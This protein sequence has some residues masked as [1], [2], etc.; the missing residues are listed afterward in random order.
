MQSENDNWSAAANVAQVAA[1]AVSSG[2]FALPA[3]SK[4]AT[5]LVTLTPGAYTAHALGG[6]GTVLLE[7]YAP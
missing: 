3:A 4:D 5:L 7:I 6:N 1:Y 2:A